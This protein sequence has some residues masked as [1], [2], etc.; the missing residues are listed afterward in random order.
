MYENGTLHTLAIPILF[1]MTFNLYINL[2]PNS[3]SYL[4]YKANF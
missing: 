4:K 2:L 3:Q 1:G